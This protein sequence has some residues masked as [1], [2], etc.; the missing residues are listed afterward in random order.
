MLRT[1]MIL[2]RDGLEVS[3]V[4][5]R[6]PRGR[7]QTDELTHGHTIVFVRRGCFV[8]NADGVESVLDPTVAYCMNAGQEQRYD[9]PHDHG[10]DCTSL[11]LH[12]DLI[13]SMWGGEEQ[14]PSVPIHTSPEIDL[15]HRLL[16]AASRSGADQHELVERAVALAAG[17][18]EQSDARPVD[19]GR[20]ATIRARR[21][22]VDGAREI[23]A[24]SPERSLPDLA[25]DLAVSPH[26]L[27]RV[28]HSLT[29]QTISS[30]RMRL[31]TRATLERLSE[32]ERDLA[33][34][35]AEV[36]FADQSHLC[37]V[38]GQETG[39]TPSSLRRALTTAA[40]QS[41]AA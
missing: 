23:L 35:A 18:L 34:I 27:S 24:R 32:G 4:A 21:A 15:E 10:D 1:R 6:H 8:R 19:S 40:I 30:H 31:R 38:V 14:L 3:E 39:S 41:P 5:C 26:H 25:R 22:A 36:G 11:V 33:R 20:P 17:A 37:R 2:Q 12:P 9:H 28:F 13:A 29:G 7:G 16:V